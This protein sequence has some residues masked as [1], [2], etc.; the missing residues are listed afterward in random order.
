MSKSL[1]PALLTH[2]Q[3]RATTMCFCWRVTRTDG[4]VQ[5]FTNHDRDLTADGTL[6]KASA[7]FTASQ[8]QS[9][10]GLAVDNLNADGALSDETLNEADLA[11]GRYD[12][13]E[14]EMLW[15]NWSDPTLFVLD[16]LGNLGEVKRGRVAFSAEVRSQAHKLNQKTGRTYQSYCD[17]KLGDGRCKVD[18]TSSTFR[19][20]GTIAAAA[21]R[22]LIVEGIG[23]FAGDWFTAGLLTFT[24]GANNGVSFEVKRHQTTGGTSSSVELW[25]EPTLVVAATDPFFITAGC[26]KDYGTCK[27]KFING[28]NFQG[29]PYIPG[30]NI[31]AGGHGGDVLDGG[32][33]YGN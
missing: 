2:L 31:I 12:N 18:L 19:G 29:F 17:A 1:Q 13:A 22:Q 25:H 33:L 3:G 5:G 30:N 32:S 21:G 24:G 26:K 15:V 20:T 8:I 28:P 27:T 11:A 10:L 6:F 9:S 16:K 4:L 14:V 23:G 7:G